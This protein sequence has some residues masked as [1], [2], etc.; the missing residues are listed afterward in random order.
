MLLSQLIFT[1]NKYDNYFLEGHVGPNFIHSKVVSK[2]LSQ[3]EEPQFFHEGTLKS[4]EETVKIEFNVDSSRL[5]S[6]V[7]IITT[8]AQKVLRKSLKDLANRAKIINLLGTKKQAIVNAIHKIEYTPDIVDNEVETNLT[9]EELKEKLD[10]AVAAEEEEHSKPHKT[11]MTAVVHTNEEPLVWFHQEDDRPK[12][13][14]RSLCIMDYDAIR[15]AMLLVRNANVKEKQVENKT[16]SIVLNTALD[17]EVKYK[18]WVK[19]KDIGLPLDKKRT[20]LNVPP[21]SPAVW[22][23]DHRV[24]VMKEDPNINET[25]INDAMK[26]HRHIRVHVESPNKELCAMVAVQRLR[27]PFTSQ[28]SDIVFRSKWQTMLGRAVIDVDV[29]GI[30]SSFGA[31]T[32]DT[33]EAKPFRHGF[34]VVALT[35]SHDDGCYLRGQKVKPINDS[36]LEVKLFR[37]KEFHVTLSVVDDGEA[38]VDGTLITLFIYVTTLAFALL[39]SLLCKI[40]ISGTVTIDKNNKWTRPSSILLRIK[41]CTSKTDKPRAIG[42]TSGSINHGLDEA[43]TGDPNLPGGV[44][45]QEMEMVDGNLDSNKPSGN[46]YRFVQRK[47]P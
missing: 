31:L 8:F 7:P 33:V 35:K 11:L 44:V 27:C 45:V 29:G 22:R 34:F 19:L 5:V 4:S 20:R 32:D 38:V 47:P 40:P 25:N 15:N 9:K 30:H 18:V 17:T 36:R 24:A 37:E 28:E 13:I 14:S 2:E 23:Y 41:K 26:L 42:E 3:T 46:K 12:N 16:I 39:L 43:G 1:E 6:R 21:D 10:D